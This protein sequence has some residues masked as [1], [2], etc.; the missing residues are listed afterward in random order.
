MEVHKHP[1]HV[2]RAKKWPEYVLEFLMIFFAVF[3]GFYA[4][5]L[6]E[7]SLERKKGKQY[8]EAFYNDLIQNQITYNHYDSLFTDLLPAYD[9]IV[10]IYHKKIRKSKI[11]RSY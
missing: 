4:E 9:S 5:K 6:R 1:R 8:L 11:Y 2:T 10:S 7:H 3:L